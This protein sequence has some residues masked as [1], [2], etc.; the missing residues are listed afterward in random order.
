[1]RLAAGCA[2]FARLLWRLWRAACP[3]LHLLEP[4]ASP[5]IAH[6]VPGVQEI[7]PHGIARLPQPGTGGRSRQRRSDSVR[8][9]YTFMIQ[10]YTSGLLARWI[11][12]QRCWP[13]P[14]SDGEGELTLTGS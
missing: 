4:N 7:R 12:D 6:E 3:H 8:G 13:H 11:A 14:S 2:A 1:M 9:C 10:A 5:G